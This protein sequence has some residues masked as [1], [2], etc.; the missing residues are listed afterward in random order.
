MTI[1]LILAFWFR[2]R[3]SLGFCNANLTCW[4][5][6]QAIM[7]IIALAVNNLHA[8]RRYPTYWWG[9]ETFRGGL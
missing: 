9:S 7:L 8:R 4:H 2:K 3:I 5:A 6:L 1:A